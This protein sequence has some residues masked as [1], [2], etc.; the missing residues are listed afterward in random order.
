[1]NG[2]NFTVSK[3]IHA[4]AAQITMTCSDECSFIL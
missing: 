4:A 2:R 3:T 1:M